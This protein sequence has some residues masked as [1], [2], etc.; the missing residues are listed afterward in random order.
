[1]LVRS[2]QLSDTM[3]RYLIQRIEENPAIELHY[4]RKSSRLEGDTQLERVTWQ[5]K[6]TGEKS[7]TTSA[8]CSSWRALLRAPS[9]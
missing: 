1:M 3:S 5:D 8:T 9:G 6:K 2:G 7:P 4:R